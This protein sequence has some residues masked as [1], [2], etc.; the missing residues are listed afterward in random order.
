MSQNDGD[1]KRMKQLSDNFVGPFPQ[2]WKTYRQG[3][4]WDFE[5]TIDK[6]EYVGDQIH[7]T[8][9]LMSGSFPQQWTRKRLDTQLKVQNTSDGKAKLIQT[10]KHF[11]HK[12]NLHSSI[13]K[14][15]NRVKRIKGGSQI[16]LILGNRCSCNN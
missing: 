11:P 15:K 5:T 4:R 9:N 2:R 10:L 6:E 14:T 8:S 7:L 12:S 1:R 16:F 13:K 3:L